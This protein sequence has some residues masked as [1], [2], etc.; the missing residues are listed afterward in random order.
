MERQNQVSTEAFAAEL[1]PEPSAR[2]RVAIARAVTLAAAMD[3]ETDGSKLSSLSREHRQV[4]ADLASQVRQSD[5]AGSAHAAAAPAS[6]S[7]VSEAQVDM[8]RDKI[9]AKRRAAGA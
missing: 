5:G 8:Y 4:M 6:P 7:V 1:F 2:Q 9:A 3:S